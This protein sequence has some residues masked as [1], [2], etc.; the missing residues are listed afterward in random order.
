M[1]PAYCVPA[2]GGLVGSVPSTLATEAYGLCALH[3]GHRAPEGSG[4]VEVLPP[5]L[6]GW[7]AAHAKT[8]VKQ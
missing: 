5:D 4:A 3:P 2:R 7:R 8:S 6:L 1:P